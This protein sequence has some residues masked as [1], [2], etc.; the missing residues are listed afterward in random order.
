MYDMS[1]TEEQTIL[2][3]NVRE[4]TKNVIMPRSKEVDIT[5]EFPWDV[6]NKVIDMGLHCMPVPEKFGGPGLDSVTSAILVEELAKGCA[7]MATTIAANGLT[8]YP[9][10]L[11][12]TEEQQK[13]Y[14][15]ILMQG[16]LAAFCLTEPNAGS[17]AG[18]VA[19]TATKDGDEYVLNGTK[20]F[21]TNGAVAS[22]YTV[23][24]SVDTSKG[25]KGLSAFIVEKDREG[26]T[27]GKEENKM[28]IR[29][30]NTTDVYFKDV[31]IP[32]NH[33]L[34]REGE[35]FKIAM[36]TLDCA[37][38]LVGAVSVGIAQAAL[39]M[40]IGYAKERKQFGKP[41]AVNQAIQFMLADMGMQI[42]A[43]RCLVHRAC[44][45]KDAGLPFGQESA[46]SKC[47]AG[48]VAMKVTVDAVQI[49][50][51]YGYS[52]DY[53]VEKLMRDA[54]IMQIFEGTNQVQRMV[55]AGQL[56]R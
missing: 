25:L 19:T 32:A 28:G 48:D 30:S 7:G 11:A 1:L 3:Q 21:I 29:A 2:K 51:G 52:R 47:Y 24:A 17:D 4:F 26:I 46:M 42:E 12:G 5:G 15:N 54:K 22:V 50:G 39:D 45:L 31:R 44:W 23:F 37:R 38:P 8:S 49:H 53:P 9:V 33:L 16:K 40:S 55:I 10:L 27:V 36:Q 18:S 14:F 6:I 13:L 34:G 20:C 41:I 35:G 56:L 43:A